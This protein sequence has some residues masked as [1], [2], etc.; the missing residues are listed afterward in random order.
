MRGAYRKSFT[1]CDTF[2]CVIAI[3]FLSFRFGSV[4]TGSDMEHPL[5]RAIRAAGM[6]V[7]SLATELGVTRAAVQQ[8]KSEGRCVPAEHCPKIE[9]LCHGAVRCEELNDRVDWKFLR[10]T[11]IAQSPAEPAAS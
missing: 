1:P 8:W 9:R 3:E 5:D 4:L 10:N 2:S 11:S 7:K 6:T